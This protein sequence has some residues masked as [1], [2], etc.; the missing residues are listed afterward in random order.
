MGGKMKK[1][2]INCK[3]ENTK[4]MLVFQ[5]EGM[6]CQ[7]CVSRVKS[8]LES[9]PKVKSAKVDLETKLVWVKGS[10][11]P[12]DLEAAVKLVG[13]Q[14][15]FLG[16]AAAVEMTASDACDSITTPNGIQT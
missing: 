8:A 7:G 2:P 11:S 14:L 15:T 6:G 13:K 12:A 16:S 3:P 4:G 10:A 1:V 9:V 5:V